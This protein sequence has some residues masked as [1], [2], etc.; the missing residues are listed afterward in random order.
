MF[1]FDVKFSIWMRTWPVSLDTWPHDKWPK[2]VRGNHI[3]MMSRTHIWKVC[4]LWFG[5]LGV[6]CSVCNLPQSSADVL[7]KHGTSPLQ[8]LG[9]IVAWDTWCHRDCVEYSPTFPKSRLGRGKWM[10]ST[11]QA[12][13]QAYSL[14]VVEVANC[15]V[16]QCCADLSRVRRMISARANILFRP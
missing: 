4:F 5:Q 8:C 16:A 6:T 1:Y 10:N 15:S 7:R 9:S 3:Q 12:N 13:F 11:M 2:F 14:L